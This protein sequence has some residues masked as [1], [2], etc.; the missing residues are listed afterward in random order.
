MN[1]EIFTCNKLISTQPASY[2]MGNGGFFL[3]GEADHSPPT[4][5]EVKK[6]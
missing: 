1:K 3:G 6:M 4:T 2:P 5:V